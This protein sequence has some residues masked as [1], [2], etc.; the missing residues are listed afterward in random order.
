MKDKTSVGFM[1]ALIEMIDTV[2]IEQ[3]RPAFDTVDFVTF[4]Q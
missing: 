2:C 4:F 3:G 1:G